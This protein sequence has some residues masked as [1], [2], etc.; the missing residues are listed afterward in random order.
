[1]GLVLAAAAVYVLVIGAYLAVRVRPSA[2][3]L[4]LETEPILRLSTELSARSERLLR[5]MQ[6]ARTKLPDT[7]V[8]P[9][10]RADEISRMIRDE[11]PASLWLLA[12]M[13][14]PMRVSLARVEDRSGVLEN[15]LWEYVS[16]LELERVESAERRLASAAPLDI[17]LRESIAEAQRTGLEDLLRRERTLAASAAEAVTVVSFW[18]LVGLILIPMFGVL[19][20]HRVAIPLTRLDGGLDRIAEGDLTV[21]LPVERDDEVGRLTGHFN[22]MTRVLAERAEAQGRFVAA[23]ELMAGV[24][25][26]VNNPLMAITTVAQLRLDD[27]DL[28]AEQRAELELIVRQARRAG[29]LVTG[30]LRFLKPREPVVRRLDLNDL[31]HDAVDLLSY[32]FG[33]DEITVA[34]EKSPTPLAI[35]ADPGG[36]EQVVVN[37]LSNAVDALNAVAPPRR[38]VIQTWEDD[39]GVC[40]AVEDS[41]TGVAPAIVDRLFLPFATSKGDR[42]NGL[43]LYISRQIAREAGGDIQ[44]VPGRS[45]GAR[46]VL[47]LP[48]APVAVGQAPV[49]RVESAPDHRPLEG[50][51]IVLVD[52][53][54]AV[55]R[56]LAKYLARRGATVLEAEDGEGA[57]ELLRDRDMDVVVADL[58]MPR[59]G[60]VELYHALRTAGSP[61]AN[62]MLFLSGDLSSLTD[63][64]EV[65]AA[66][67]RVVAKPVELSELERRILEVAAL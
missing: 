62:H 56:P 41:G 1:M 10:Q 37:L 65:P 39:D 6:L 20:R 29:K 45:R 52:D 5:A 60:G 14:A 42:G 7:P 31:V 55:R 35:E 33:V 57:L 19:M 66:V 61:S 15:V 43:G 36:L 25:H 13:P 22:D 26:E 47:R 40:L 28:T 32:R 59:M 46:F 27:L 30:L 18:V 16:L 64:G 44:L 2:R 38:L 67:G 51:D 23:G 11:V 17:R 54:A 3:T 53:E 9:Q 8:A 48:A 58:R 21:R 50:L 4:D 34:L 12:D 49:A 63:S 24:A